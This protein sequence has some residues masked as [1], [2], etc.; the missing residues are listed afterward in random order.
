MPNK[1]WKALNELDRIVRSACPLGPE[2]EGLAVT[3]EYRT[4]FELFNT[5]PYHNYETW[6]GGYYIKGLGVITQAEDLDDAI[7]RWADLVKRK[8]KGE[9]L[10][11]GSTY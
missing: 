9:K 4:G 10:P 11:V 6:S 2:T 3:I 7:K 8:N 1:E 5:R